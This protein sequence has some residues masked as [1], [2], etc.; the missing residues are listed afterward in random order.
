MPRIANCVEKSLSAGEGVGAGRAY[1][2]PG[3]LNTL[4]AFHYP[5]GTD[6]DKKFYTS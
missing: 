5:G 2:L 1:G 3:V 4:L 6:S